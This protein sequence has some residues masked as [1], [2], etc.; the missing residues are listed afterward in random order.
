LLF[1]VEFTVLFF[2]FNFISTAALIV[3]KLGLK[4]RLRLLLS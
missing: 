1:F 2:C 3:Y 4:I